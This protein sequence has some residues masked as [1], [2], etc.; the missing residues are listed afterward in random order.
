MELSCHSS[1]KKEEVI[2]FIKKLVGKR[3]VLHYEGNTYDRWGDDY[4]TEIFLDDEGLEVAID[5]IKKHYIHGA[6][7]K[8][9]A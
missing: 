6:W 3:I 7:E 8:T 9:N 5:M 4:F 2:D 1:T